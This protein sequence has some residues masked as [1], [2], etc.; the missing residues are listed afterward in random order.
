MMTGTPP[1]LHRARMH[2]TVGAKAGVPEFGPPISKAGFRTDPMPETVASVLAEH[3]ARHGPGPAGLV[4]T[5]THWQSAHPERRRR[6]VAPR[7]SQSGD[8][9]RGPPPPSSPHPS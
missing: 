7:R 2:W 1:L 6:D 3:V 5:N 4:F 8:P 9:P